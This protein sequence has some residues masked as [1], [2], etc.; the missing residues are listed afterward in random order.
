MV[1]HLSPP[2]FI[3]SMREHRTHRS[4]TNLHRQSLDDCNHSFEWNP[5]VLSLRT[6]PQMTIHSKD[7]TIMP[8]PNESQPRMLSGPACCFRTRPQTRTHTPKNRLNWQSITSPKMLDGLPQM[9]G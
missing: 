3:A 9:Y 4:T 1:D 7:Q 5:G 2:L 6:N 8:S